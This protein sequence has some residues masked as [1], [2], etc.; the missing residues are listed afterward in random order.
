M[1]GNIPD[2]IHV[3]QLDNLK[4]DQPANTRGVKPILV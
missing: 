3:D 4:L 1:A 2:D